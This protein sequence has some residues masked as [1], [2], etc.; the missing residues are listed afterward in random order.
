MSEGLFGTQG[1]PYASFKGMGTHYEGKIVNTGQVHSRKYVP[2]S[3][4]AA[5]KQGDLEYW[6][7]G[8][9]K[10]TAIITVQTGL[11]DATIEGDDGE[12]S[13]WISGKSMTDAV[14]AAVKQA[15]CS[16]RGIEIGGY[17]SITFTH[18]TPPEEEGLNP[19]KHYAVEYRPPVQGAQDEINIVAPASTPA[20]VPQAAQQAYAG[21]NVAA[22]PSPAQAAQVA[23]VASSNGMDLSALSPEARAA[24]EAMMAAQGGQQ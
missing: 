16:R 21:G 11:R 12:R 9:P 1:A 6:P 13:I 14:K 7:D 4:R 20:A 17:F 5:G 19:T 8:K 2:A 3:Q 24:V 23:S 15:G 22:Q 10:M 18:E